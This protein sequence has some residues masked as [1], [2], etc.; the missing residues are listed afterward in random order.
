MSIALATRRTGNHG[1][2]RELPSFYMTEDTLERYSRQIRF[3][4]LGAGG[5]ESLLSSCV[6]I[7][8]CGALGSFQ[9]GALARAGVGRLILIDR[10]F[11][12]LSNLQRQWLYDEADAAAAV[13]K[14]VAAARAIA[15]FASGCT[16]TTHVADLTAGNISD[17][18]DGADLLMD[19]TDNFETRYLINEYAVRHRIAWV[20][21]GAVGSYGVTM[22]VVPGVTACF[23]CVY[24]AAPGGVLPTCETAG[25]LGPATSLV[26]S[27]Q[28]AQ[29]LR[30]LS[31][32]GA[33]PTITTADVWTG[34]IRQIA[35]PDPNPDCA[36][37]ALGRFEL[38][39]RE[40]RVPISL[41]GRNAVQIHERS[42]PLDLGELRRQLSGCCEVRM[43]EFGLRFFPEN[44]EITVFPDG[45][46]IIKGTTDT[47]VARSLY[48]RFIGS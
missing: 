35:V 39:E 1:I 9:G 24:P 17:L 37:C 16:L 41:C 31:G 2:A 15:R 28:S 32:N 26:A 30:I 27:L 47:G 18:L 23:A 48:S 40:R 22:P 13:P 20:Y 5:Q 33:N 25:V 8:G 44:Y 34:A 4:P 43:N 7:I 3:T 36:V 45:R 6:A 21:G 19:G 38:L 11:V 29:A 42:R 10:D 46:A 12:E 14:A